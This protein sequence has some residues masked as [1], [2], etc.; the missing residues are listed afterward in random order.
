MIAYRIQPSD[1]AVLPTESTT[2]TDGEDVRAGASCCR[3]VAAII[4]YFQ[5]DPS[6]KLRSRTTREQLVDVDMLTVEG[7]W[8][9]DLDHDADRAAPHGPSSPILVVDASIVERRSLSAEEVA[10]ILIGDILGPWEA[11][12]EEDDVG[13]ARAALAASWGVSVATLAELVRVYA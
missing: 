10:E 7:T 13:A 4:A 11:C 1:R 8:S 3:S 6:G 2:W 12:D 5:R 9:D